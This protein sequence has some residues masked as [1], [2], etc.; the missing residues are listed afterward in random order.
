MSSNA[1]QDVPAT[2]SLSNKKP[3]SEERRAMLRANLEKAMEKRRE[4]S[5]LRRRTKEA[6][7]DVLK[8]REL[9]RLEKLEEE[10]KKPHDVP[11][12]REPSPPSGSSTESEEAPAPRPKSS[13]TRPQQKK[14]SPPTNPT[15]RPPRTQA[16]RIEKRR[17]VPAKH[18]AQILTPQEALRQSMRHQVEAAAMR[19]L[20]PFSGMGGV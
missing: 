10:K 1:E 6:E 18:V 4:I 11:A 13:T 12:T 2:P 20:F 9:A 8:K 16:P 15:P 7:L 5:E 17:A 3:V 14:A 19:S